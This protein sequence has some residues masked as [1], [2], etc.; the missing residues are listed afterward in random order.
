MAIETELAELS[1][2]F[3]N[4][5]LDAT[6]AFALVLR[7]PAEVEGLPDSVRAAAAQSARENAGDDASAGR[8]PPPS[9]G[10]WRITLEA[11]LYVP[12]MEHA[13]RR[14]LRERLYRAFVT[15]ASSGEQDNQPLIRRILR[16][17]PGGGRSC[18]AS[19]RSPSWAC[20]ARW[21]SRC[22]RSRRCWTSCAGPADRAP[23]ASW[24]S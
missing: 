20:S 18:W 2:R 10:P 9:A 19:A 16:A 5:L 17:A 24:P 4:N 15:R 7:D 6:K 12:F 13:R 14:D 8:R 11:P 21:P 1:T 3:S 23:S 22:R